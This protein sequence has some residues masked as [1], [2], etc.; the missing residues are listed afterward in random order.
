M[1]LQRS[2]TLPRVT[3]LRTA[4]MESPEKSGAGPM[5]GPGYLARAVALHLAGQREEALK[6]LQRAVAAN[7]KSAEIYRAMGHIQ[8]ELGNFQESA[9]SY[10]TLAQLK[11]STP[12]A[13]SIWRSRWN[14]A[15]LGTTLRG[16]SQGMHAR[17]Q[18]LEAQLGLGV[19]HLRMEDPSPPWG[20]SSVAWNSPPITRTRCS[21]RPSPCSRWPSR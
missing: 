21:A 6:Q 11:P 10:R 19:C 5:S 18:A 14:A 17:S 1:T 15:T 7:E 8:F 2:E 4:H 3:S 16:L 12:W 9:K 20:L 13:G